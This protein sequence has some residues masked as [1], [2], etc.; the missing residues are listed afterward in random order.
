VRK[1]TSNFEDLDVYQVK[2][3]DQLNYLGMDKDFKIIKKQHK[4]KKNAK[5]KSRFHNL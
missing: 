1:Y 5:I 4:K 2:L 3:R